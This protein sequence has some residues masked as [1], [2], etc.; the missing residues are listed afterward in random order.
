MFKFA[1]YPW[2]C[3]YVE[4]VRKFVLVKYQSVQT[5]RKQQLASQKKSTLRPQNNQ[6]IQTFIYSLY[7]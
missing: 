3:L 4:M 1:R 6:G 5:I 2:F 7:E